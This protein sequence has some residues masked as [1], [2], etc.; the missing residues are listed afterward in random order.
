MALNEHIFQELKTLYTQL[1]NEG[2][3]LTEQ[4]LNECYSLFRRRF[5]P[6]EIS[7][8]E[9]EAL[10]NNIHLHGNYDSLVYWLEFKKFENT[11]A[12]T[13][14]KKRSTTANTAEDAEK[15]FTTHPKNENLA[16]RKYA[17]DNTNA[18]SWINMVAVAL[19]AASVRWRFL[20]L[21]T[22]MMESIE[23]PDHLAR[24]QRTWKDPRMVS[25][26]YRSSRC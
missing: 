6:D 9:G 10:L 2:K 25:T 16:A 4:K 7:K 13:K 14:P 15:T 8:W 20:R 17:S 18:N 21:I 23:E 19:G 24:T 26:A 1:S 22:S 11:L 3:V 5:G 12:Q